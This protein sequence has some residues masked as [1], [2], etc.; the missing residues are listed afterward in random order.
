L[1]RGIEPILCGRSVRTSSGLPQFV[2]QGLDVG[3]SELRDAMPIR[4]CFGML[5]SLMRMFQDFPGMFVPREVFPF[6][7]LLPRTMGMRRSVM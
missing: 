3:V 1:F 7:L 5:M 6:S 4:S 2:S